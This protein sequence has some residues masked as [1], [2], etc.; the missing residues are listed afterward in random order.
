MM[1]PHAKNLRNSSYLPVNFDDSY[2]KSGL[3]FLHKVRPESEKSLA[4]IKILIVEDME[5]CQ[6]IALLTFNQPTYLADLAVTGEE[7][8][9]K[10]SQGYDVIL[11]DLGLPDMSGIEVC[12]H[13]RKKIGDTKTPIIAYSA[14]SDILREECLAV[15]FN[16]TLMKPTEKKALDSVIKELVEKAS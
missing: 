6:K 1:I 8:I 11:L 12:T 13:I 16:E 2:D 5:I 4:P 3:I 7:A 10:Y 9:T 14:I 15:G